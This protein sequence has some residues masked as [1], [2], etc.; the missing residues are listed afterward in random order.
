[1]P[2]KNALCIHPH[3][4]LD[5]F[6]WNFMLGN[7]IK[8]SKKFWLCVNQPT[9]TG[10]ICDYLHALLQSGW[11]ITSPITT[12]IAQENASDLLERHNA[13][14]PCKYHWLQLLLQKS[15]N[16]TNVYYYLFEFF[17]VTRLWAVFFQYFIWQKSNPA[18]CADNCHATCTP[19]FLIC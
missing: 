9:I 11:V 3:E 6:P 14:H 19:T 16:K 1:M 8:N 17:K 12:T 18:E 5:G 10:T 13:P 4:Q 7:F 15:Q 2:I